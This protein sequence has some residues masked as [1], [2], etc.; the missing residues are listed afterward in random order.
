MTMAGLFLAGGGN[1]KV[2]AQDKRITCESRDGN[3]NYCRVDTDNKVQLE[4]KL[5]LS[6]CRYG[7]SW[8]YDKRGI[9][10]N[11][12]CRGEFTY[13]GSSSGKTAVAV[14]A[15]L[16]GLILAGALASRNK[17]ESKIYYSSQE[18][19]D[20]GFRDGSSDAQRGQ[21]NNPDA[22]RYEYE[23]KYRDD[24]RRGYAAGYAS[25]NTS[26]NNNAV[27]KGYAAGAQDARNNY[28][29]DYSRYRYQYN[30]STE[31]DFRRG[32]NDGYRDNRNNWSSG[33]YGGGDRVPNYFI[34][35]F[36]GFTPSN[37]T[38]TDIT[39]HA[40]GSIRISN[41][42][43]D[44]ANGYFQDGAA[45]FPWGRFR[46]RKEGNGFTAVDPNNRSASILYQ[47]IR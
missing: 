21:G 7:S 28:S 46:L 25:V 26:N 24:F 15:V 3:Y 39:I 14:G 37:N 47:R 10:V 29:S 33:N 30:W 22:H 38:F 18:V 40:D 16:G 34:G 23:S 4:R 43:G 6:E 2:L 32:Y 11:R 35:T 31:T 20:L 1:S 5:S 45:I 12:G 19:Y 36:R 44:Q 41:F 8:G 13:G 42:K 27:A 9:W 17:D